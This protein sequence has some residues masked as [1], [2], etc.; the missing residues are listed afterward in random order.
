[1]KGKGDENDVIQGQ[2]EDNLWVDLC[3]GTKKKGK[4]DLKKNC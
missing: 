2:F 4:Q 1:M 3:T